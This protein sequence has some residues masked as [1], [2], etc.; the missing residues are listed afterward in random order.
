MATRSMVDTT[1]KELSYRKKLIEAAL[2]LGATDKAAA[3]EN[4]AWHGHPPAD[5]PP[6]YAASRPAE[7]ALAARLS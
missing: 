5:P 4:L 1:H 2:P 6:A 7:L 3:G